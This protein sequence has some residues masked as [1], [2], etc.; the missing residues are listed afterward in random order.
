VSA[1]TIIAGAGMNSETKATDSPSAG[2]DKHGQIG[3]AEELKILIN[4]NEM[5][6]LTPQA[7]A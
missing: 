6:E 4:R 5:L 3:A 7:A 2:T 1:L